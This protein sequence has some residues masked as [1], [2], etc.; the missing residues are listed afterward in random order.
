[1]NKRRKVIF[2]ILF[3]WLYKIIYFHVNIKYNVNSFLLYLINHII[4]N[5]HGPK[6]NTSLKSSCSPILPLV[7]KILSIT[8]FSI[9]R[10]HCSDFCCSSSSIDS[11]IILFHLIVPPLGAWR[12]QTHN[13]TGSSGTERH[14][15]ASPVF[16]WL[17]LQQMQW[18]MVIIIT[19]TRPE[20]KAQQGC[21]VKVPFEYQW[22]EEPENK[23]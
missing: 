3:H 13:S 17:I 20:H 5:I 2:H 15:C 8:L 6:K 18:N 16:K 9:N 23:I 7:L 22:M 4:Q 14:K 19:C 21:L 12:I 1:M 10:Q 11:N